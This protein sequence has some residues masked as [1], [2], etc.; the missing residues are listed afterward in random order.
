[1][2]KL[3]KKLQMKKNCHTIV[4]NFKKIIEN[5]QFKN[6]KKK[7]SSLVHGEGFLIVYSIT[8][9]VSFD[10]VMELRDIILR[11]KDAENYPMVTKLKNKKKK[12]IIK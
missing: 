12:K 11:Y 4:I 2:K 1:M 8:S 7:E 3:K 9:R 5:E 10:R 6:N